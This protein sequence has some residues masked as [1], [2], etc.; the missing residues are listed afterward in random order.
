MCKLFFLKKKNND[1]QNCINV[2]SCI[3]NFSKNNQGIKHQKLESSARDLMFAL[4]SQEH[5][6]TFRRLAKVIF[7]ILTSSYSTK[8]SVLLFLRGLLITNAAEGLVEKE[9]YKN[10]PPRP[11]KM[12]HQIKAFCFRED[13]IWIVSTKPFWKYQGF[14]IKGDTSLKCSF[15]G[16]IFC[17]LDIK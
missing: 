8:H 5:W 7:R 1:L 4:S 13:K 10:H 2:C 15:T 11:A 12:F 16:T 3:R 14:I 6:W 9:A 17:W